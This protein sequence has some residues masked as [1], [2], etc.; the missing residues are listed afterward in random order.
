MA[1]KREELPESANFRARDESS[2]CHF[3]HTPLP[4]GGGQKVER[5]AHSPGMKLARRGAGRQCR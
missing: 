4:F 2:F 1:G 5:P 3:C